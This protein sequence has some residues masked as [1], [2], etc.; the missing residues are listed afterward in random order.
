MIVI[1]P[2]GMQFVD[3]GPNVGNSTQE[4]VFRRQTGSALVQ[5]PFRPSKQTMSTGPVD[6]HG[7]FAGPCGAAARSCRWARRLGQLFPPR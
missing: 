1:V 4:P 5:L 7:P 3:I 2:A 6:F